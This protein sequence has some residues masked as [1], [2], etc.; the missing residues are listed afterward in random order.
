MVAYNFQSRFVPAIEAGTKRQTIRA[1]GKRRHV[2]P[3]GAIQLYTG[4]RTR[5]C[6]KLGDAVALR[7]VPIRL[8]R[9]GGK[10][11]SITIDGAALDPE[12]LDAFARADGFSDAAEMAAYWQATNG[13]AVV[14]EGVLIEW[15]QE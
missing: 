5:G 7:V 3:G 1:H 11:R 9:H 6:R 13:D 8:E 10:Y 4:M 14:F 12:R 15:G 2:R